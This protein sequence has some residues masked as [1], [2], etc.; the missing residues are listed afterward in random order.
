[1]TFVLFP[2]LP[3]EKHAEFAGHRMTFLDRG[4]GA[5]RIDPFGTRLGGAD[6]DE[7]EDG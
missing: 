2:I 5:K 4:N 7:R 1:M 6:A 3:V